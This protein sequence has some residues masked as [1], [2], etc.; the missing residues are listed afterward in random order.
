MTAVMRVVPKATGA[1]VLRIGLVV[2][3]RILDERVIKQRTSVTVGQSERSMFVVDA[4]VPP[5]FK[6][7]ERVGDRYDLNILDGMTGRVALSTGVDDLAALKAR[8]RRVARGYALRLT[9]EARGQIVIGKTTFLFQFVEPPPVQPRPHLPLS[10]KDGITGQIDWRLTVI[11]A[12][13]F[14]L[15]FG[16]LGAMYSD[17]MDAVVS[18]GP[19]VGIIQVPPPRNDIAVETTAGAASTS[20]T[21]SERTPSPEPMARARASDGNKSLKGSAGRERNVDALMNALDQMGFGVIQSLNGGPN[22]RGLT[23]SGDNGAPVD[24]EALRNRREAIS[25]TRSGLNLPGVD[26]P[27]QLDRSGFTLPLH[28]TGGASTSAGRMTRVAP[29]GDVKEDAPSFSGSLPDAEAVIRSQIHPGA[30]RCYQRGLD[31]DPNQAG[32]LLLSIRVAPSGEVESANIS[33]D[34]GLSAAVANC[35]AAVARRARFSPT[36]PGGATIVVPF[37]F[38]RQG[39]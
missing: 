33:T 34:A 5:Q 16:G 37:G 32:K 14:L 22:I 29:V 35:I 26:R 6:L 9:D 31:S 13:S 20:G 4:N 8:A 19:V 39:G 30:K 38:V 3:G 7:F 25:D 18:D 10:V 12:F 15:H 27:L 17:W 1:R 28:D 11:A 24:L 2:A 36:G 21:P 23:A